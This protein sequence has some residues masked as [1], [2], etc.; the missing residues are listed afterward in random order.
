MNIHANHATKMN[1]LREDL[2]DNPEYLEAYLSKQSHFKNKSETKPNDTYFAKQAKRNEEAK[3][4]ISKMETVHINSMEEELT[5]KEHIEAM[6]KVCNWK[7]DNWDDD[8]VYNTECDNMFYLS[9]DDT[10]EE[11]KFKY[12]PYCGGE[13]KYAIEK[14]ME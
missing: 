11:H 9:T 10:P 7:K 12:C 5:Y 6:E 4:T 1:E 13:L 3:S 8:N 2:K 14:L